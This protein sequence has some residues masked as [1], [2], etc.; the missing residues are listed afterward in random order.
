[1]VAPLFLLITATK[2]IGV[3]GLMSV[4]ANLLSSHRRFNTT[5]TTNNNNNKK[6]QKKKKKKES[7]SSSSEK[8]MNEQLQQVLASFA[9]DKHGK[10]SSYL[11][12]DFLIFILHDLI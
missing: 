9:I 10:L 8:P 3:V 12:L 4:A 7:S 5:T 2:F 1:M 6:K 11:C